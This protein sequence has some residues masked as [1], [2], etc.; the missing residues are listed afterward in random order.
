MI[1]LLGYYMH[2]EDDLRYALL[3]DITQQWV[4]IPIFQELRIP[5]FMTL[6][7]GTDRL[8]WNVGTELPLSTALYPRRVQISSVL[9]HKPEIM[10]GDDLFVKCDYVC[11]EDDLFVKIWL[12][13]W[14][15][16]VC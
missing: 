3:W 13:V 8:S 14:R 5:R 11:D 16:F 15:R 9:Q 12:C 10:H 6:E 7:G 2:D 4:V 1:C